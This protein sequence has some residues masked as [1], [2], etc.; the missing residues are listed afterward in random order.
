MRRKRRQPARVL[1]TMNREKDKLGT[2]QVFPDKIRE[3]IRKNAISDVI[4]DK[5]TQ[6]DTDIKL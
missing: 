6:V 5:K 1:G 2:V 3:L 4:K